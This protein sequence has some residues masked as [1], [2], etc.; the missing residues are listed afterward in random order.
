MIYGTRITTLCIAILLS[1]SLAASAG[2]VG[3]LNKFENNTKADADEVNANFNAVKS[4]V[5][6]NYDRILNFS[7]PKSASVTY[8]AMG[9]TPKKIDVNGNDF[10]IEF[11]KHDDGS[12]TALD[13]GSFYHSITLR[14]GVTITQIRAFVYDGDIEGDT[15]QI[16]IKL[17]KLQIK[18]NVPEIVP[19][20][21]G[22]QSKNIGYHL[23]RANLEETI[24][25]SDTGYPSTY[26]IE[27]YFSS[28]SENLKFYSVTIDYEYTEP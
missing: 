19:I 5:D 27:V 9:F 22:E 24:E 6:D 14:S 23:I 17:T 3:D 25:W 18:E 21:S 7:A 26:F 11:E 8:S 1:L 20:V 12:L 16:E 15:G 4:A 13:S 2:E 28:N 10:K